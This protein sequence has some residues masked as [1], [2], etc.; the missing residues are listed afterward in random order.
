MV[1]KDRNSG[2]PLPGRTSTDWKVFQHGCGLRDAAPPLGGVVVPPSASNSATRLNRWAPT[3]M[4]EA[5]RHRYVAC[6]PTNLA[7]GSFR[8]DTAIWRKSPPLSFRAV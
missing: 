1:P 8:L 2:T 5:Y 3:I 6:A 4:Q 7:V